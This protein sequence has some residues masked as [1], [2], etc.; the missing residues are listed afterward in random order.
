MVNIEDIVA[1][2]STHSV[3]NTCTQGSRGRDED[4]EQVCEQSV[5]TNIINDDEA[6]LLNNIDENRMSSIP[7]RCVNIKL[8]CV[9]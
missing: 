8:I 7:T 2:P 6:T 9:L 5:E 3:G 4:E 1:F